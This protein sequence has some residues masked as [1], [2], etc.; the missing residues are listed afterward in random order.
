[1]YQQAV[2]RSMLGVKTA[3]YVQ[4]QYAK[5]GPDAPM[6]DWGEYAFH[7]AWMNRMTASPGECRF[8][9]IVKNDMEPT[10][11]RGGVVLIDPQRK[12][13]NGGIF[14]FQLDGNLL[15][16]RLAEADGL[17]S[18]TADNRAYSSLAAK[19]ENIRILGQAIWQGSTLTNG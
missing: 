9:R 19:L 3:D 17:I 16:R 1:M 11:Q 10:I 15:V 7:N 14:A 18:I 12:Q 8:V 2:D 13:P 6:E 5:L 4:V